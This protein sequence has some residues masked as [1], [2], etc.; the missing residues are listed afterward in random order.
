MAICWC[1]AE[2]RTNLLSYPP[3]RLNEKL[4]LTNK[5]VNNELDLK[6]QLAE[7]HAQ[8]HGTQA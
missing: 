1:Q 6:F 8:F 3:K 5:Y 4:Y 7:I 2:I